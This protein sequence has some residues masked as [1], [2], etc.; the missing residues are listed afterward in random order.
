MKKILDYKIERAKT[1]IELE[2]KVNRALR[3]GW[4]P[5]GGIATASFG[6]SPIG[7]NSFIQALVK[8]KS[9]K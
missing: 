9:K 4:E 5:I 2:Q 6:A 8:Y 3:S 7:G 1:E